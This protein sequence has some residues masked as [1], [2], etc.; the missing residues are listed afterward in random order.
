MKSKGK[1]ITNNEATELKDFILSNKK[2][3]PFIIDVLDLE[4]GDNKG[5]VDEGKHASTFCNVLL[6]HR[7]NYFYCYEG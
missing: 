3:L 1:P 5:S 6:H 4:R 2:H 7:L